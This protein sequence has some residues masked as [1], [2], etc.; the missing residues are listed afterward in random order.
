MK[1]QDY[2]AD[3]FHNV[4]GWLEEGAVYAAEL[5]LLSQKD[6]NIEGVN[7]EIGVWKGKY[8]GAII[9][10]TPERDAHGID[11]WLHNQEDNVK[12]F[13]GSI[14]AN[15]CLALHRFNSYDLDNEN[16]FT[17]INR[18]KLAFGS[19]DGSHNMNVVMH[20]LA[21]IIRL[22]APGG[23]I[24]IDD[25]LNPLCLGVTEGVIEFLKIN[26]EIEPICWI[27]NKLFVTTPG[28]SELY[29]IRLR[30]WLEGGAAKLIINKEN[31]DWARHSTL[32]LGK[33]LLV[34]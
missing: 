15:T 25:F 22:L 19:I 30:M 2:L 31:V 24:A 20:D 12:A 5:L 17:L 28:W 32:L 27:A 11:V 14:S 21:N 34:L 3:Y 1:A 33:L 16:F 4:D 26:N 8:L 13:L 23:I 6:L 18:K 7:L 9:A 29:Q 10:I